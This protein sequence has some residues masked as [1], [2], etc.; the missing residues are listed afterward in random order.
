METK[1][2]AD[3]VPCESRKS[4]SVLYFGDAAPRAYSLKDAG[5]QVGWYD[6]DDEWSSHMLR[7]G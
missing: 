3:P 4:G 2:L 6:V 5:F 7:I 1:P